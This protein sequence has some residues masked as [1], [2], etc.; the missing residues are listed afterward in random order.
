[1]IVLSIYHHDDYIA[2]NLYKV[3]GK[4]FILTETHNIYEDRNN[5]IA[6]KRIIGKKNIISKVLQQDFQ[7]TMNYEIIV[8]H[9]AD[10]INTPD[11]ILHK[12][13]NGYRE[14]GE[15]SRIN[16]DSINKLGQIYNSLT[17]NNELSLSHKLVT[18]FSNTKHYACFDDSFNDKNNSLISSKC[19]NFKS[20]THKLSDITTKKTTKAKVIIIHTDKS[21]HFIT[22]I[23]N[24][25]N[26]S[27]ELIPYVS[28]Q[29]ISSKVIAN[30]VCNAAIEIGGLDILI[31][32]GNETYNNANLREQ[33]C[34]HLEWIGIS[35]SNKP[36]KS[37]TT[38]LH[39]KS[40]SIQVFT[41]NPEPELAMLDMLGER[42]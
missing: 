4:K 3:Y 27:F 14:F 15:I 24:L 25:I 21:A 20:I 18:F 42:L 7:E 38:K 29:L 23:K 9:I 11:I 1:M 2:Y 6:T 33:I 31:F 16:D 39:K 41:L 5:L 30:K 36:N 17:Q 13:S 22:G 19:L 10:L 8:T 34:K 40:S 26:Y 35:I 28:E 32:S 12:I 37:N